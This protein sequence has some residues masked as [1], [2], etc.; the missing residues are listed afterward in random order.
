MYMGMY[1]YITLH[2]ITNK[3][4]YLIIAVEYV[5]CFYFAAAVS[6]ALK[7][8]LLLLELVCRMCLS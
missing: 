7:Q 8:Q 2:L 5:K 4:L 3:H 1:I 6:F